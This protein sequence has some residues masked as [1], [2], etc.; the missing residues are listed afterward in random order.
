VDHRGSHVSAQWLAALPPPSAK[1][2]DAVRLNRQELTGF[3]HDPTLNHEHL[4]LAR[5]AAEASAVLDGPGPLFGRVPM[6][7]LG[8]ANTHLSWSDLPPNLAKTFDSI[9]LGE[10]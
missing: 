4:D 2:P 8:A 9:W 1:E 10:Q 6:L 7:V 3:E 5:S